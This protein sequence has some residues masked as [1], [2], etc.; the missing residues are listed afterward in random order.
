MA[1]ILLFPESSEL[2]TLYR[3]KSTSLDSRLIPTGGG[4]KKKHLL[5]VGLNSG[6]AQEFTICL[7]GQ[8]K[9][10]QLRGISQAHK[11]RDCDVVGIRSVMV[12][13]AKSPYQASLEY[14]CRSAE[15]ARGS[16]WPRSDPWGT[17]DVACTTDTEWD[18]AD[19]T[20]KVRPV[21]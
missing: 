5:I 9:E 4:W 8:S 2:A 3:R 11:T 20:C 12:M 1:L 17:P 10:V 19:F 6:I 18:E 13:Y 16:Q 21:R 7:E 15:G 14:R